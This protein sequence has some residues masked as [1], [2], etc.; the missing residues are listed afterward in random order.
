MNTPSILVVEPDPITFQ[1]LRTLITTH[2]S[3]KILE[4]RNAVEAKTAAVRSQPSVVVIHHTKAQLDGIQLTQ[5][6]LTTASELSVLLVCDDYTM[7]QRA[8]EVGV[9][10]YI[11]TSRV[12]IDLMPAIDQLLQ[13]RAFFTAESIK[14]LRIRYYRNP[15]QGEHPTLTQ[16]EVGILQQIAEGKINKEISLAL[17]I[18]VRTV[19]NHRAG[20]MKKLRF[21][22]VSELVRYAVRNGIIEP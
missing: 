18:S 8:F 15:Y 19:E 4:A 1:G 6:I 14:G 11:L 21:E 7:I 3:W 16:R 5:G 22:H 17:G 9:L 2:R 20:I 10:G 12:K 13:G